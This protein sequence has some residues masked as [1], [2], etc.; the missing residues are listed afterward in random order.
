MVRRFL[1]VGFVLVPCVAAMASCGSSASPG[2]A[3]VDGATTDGAISDASASGCPADV[4]ADG[5]PCASPLLQCEYGDFAFADCNATATC[6]TKGWSVAPALVD[7][8][9]QNN[10]MCPASAAEIGR[11]QPC[12]TQGITCFYPDATCACTTRASADA[13]ALWI[14]DDGPTDCPAPRPHL[15]APCAD[16]G[17]TCDYSSCG[18]IRNIEERCDRG[19]WRFVFPHCDGG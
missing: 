11:G 12:T 16:E 15:G 18:L 17:E 19:V 14:C 2:T 8:C 4:P 6:T 9:A 5:T 10:T 13:Q 1:F 7:T 3:P